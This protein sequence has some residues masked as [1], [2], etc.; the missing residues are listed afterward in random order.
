MKIVTWDTVTTEAYSFVAMEPSRAPLSKLNPVVNKTNTFMVQ[1]HL[2]V[3]LG[4]L[5]MIGMFAI[6]AIHQSVGSIFVNF[7]PS[8]FVEY[9]IG[10]F[11]HLKLK[12]NFNAFK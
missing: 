5:W 11:P 10:F 8:F 3:F 9:K 12:E 6:V 1:T 7:C 2:S 4:S